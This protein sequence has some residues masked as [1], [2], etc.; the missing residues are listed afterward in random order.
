MGRSASDLFIFV[1]KRLLQLIPVLIGVIVL[2][3]FVTHLKL[4]GI[5]NEW[6]PK[7]GASTIANCNAKYG[8][9]ITTQFVQYVTTLLQ[10]NWGQSIQGVQ[11][12]PTIA[13]A[14]PATVELVLA[15]LFL[16]VVI[17]IPMG[18]IAARYSGRWGDHLVRIFYLSG[19]ATPTY[20]GAVLAAVFL[21]PYLGLPTRG[22]YSTVVPPSRSTPTCRSSMR[23]SRGT[24]RTPSTRCST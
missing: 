14:L 22:E 12:Y 4:T 21:G 23:S 18:V 2:T 5:C 7:A 15:A 24:S 9:P 16:M 6:Y 13:A 20:L 10:G 1:L 3:F 11:V 8:Q 19:W 17:G